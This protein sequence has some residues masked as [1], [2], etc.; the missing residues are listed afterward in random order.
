MK[1]SRIL[2]QS[3]SRRGLGHLMRGLNL[4]RE[5]RLLVPSVEMLFYIRS[6]SAAAL[7]GHDV[8]CFIETDA[9]GTAHWPDV[10]RSFAP[11]VVIYD[12]LLPKD[13]ANE[14]MLA[15]ARSV[16]IMRKSKAEK[17][18]EIFDNP[19]LDRVDLILIPHTPQEFAYVIPPALKR[20]SVF[21]GPIVRSPDAASQQQLRKKYRIGLG[22]F[23]LTSTAG[24]ADLRHRPNRFLRR[25][26]PS[27]GG[28]TRP[29]R[30]CGTW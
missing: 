12:T 27:T 29:Y 15:T 13:P 10:L 25:C 22:D 6:R 16:Y 26:L 19:I 23:L 5:L 20:K 30:A 2:F 1:P 14:P 8:R 18:Q 3:Y 7:C 21:V 9:D 24:G 17:Q 11:D 4:A 28:Y